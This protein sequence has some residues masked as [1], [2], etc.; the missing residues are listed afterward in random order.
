MSFNSVR[1]HSSLLT[2]ASVAAV[3][4]CTVGPHY[5]GAPPVAANAVHAAAFNRAPKDVVSPSPA[6]ATWWA[7]LGDPKLTELIETALA[8]S[9]DI[10]A[11]QARLRQSRAGLREKQRDALPKGSASAAYLHAHLPSTPLGVGSAD[12]YN[13][14]FDATW[15]ID[16]FGGTRRAVEAASA[17]AAA[18]EAD[19]ADTHVQLAAEVAQAYVDLR[20]QQQRIALVRESAELEQQILTLTQQRRERGVASDLDVERIRT[21]VENTRTTIIPLDAQIAESLDQLAVLTGREPGALDAELV[22]ARS[23]PTLP[24]TVA[25]GDPAALLRQRP[26]IRAAE[27]RLVSQNAQIGEREADWFPKLT[28]FGD[29]GFSS[30]S[31]GH[32]VRQDNFMWLGVPYI[33]WNALDFGRTRARVD[34]AK[35]GLDEAEAKYES[36]VLGALRDA[37]IALSRYGHQRDNVVSL[38]NVE[39]SASHT[40]TLTQQR[41]RAGT[42][43]ALDWL[44]AERTRFS[45]EQNRIAGDAELIK[46]YVALQ[47]SLGLGWQPRAGGGV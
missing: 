19:L 2:V 25:I 8:R 42:T 1:F 45:A 34:Q 26:D 41:Y 18:V 17:E 29:L 9:P 27:W 16:L 4:G 3:A 33:Q 35:A 44:D 22:E 28:L 39:V 36:T 6:V 14:G 32:L 46:Y 12:L 21:Q 7:A 47:K 20:D 37:N 24:S 38:R 40:A 13:V 11:A 15:E 31:P 23:L 30:A 5:R 43:S 10:R